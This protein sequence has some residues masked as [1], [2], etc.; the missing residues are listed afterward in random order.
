[1]DSE[2]PPVA[3]TELGKQV[4]DHENK[5]L[6]LPKPHEDVMSACWAVMLAFPC[7]ALPLEDDSMVV[8][9]RETRHRPVMP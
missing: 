7:V 3:E 5:L 2:M 1:M 6:V 9:D 4:A 8:H